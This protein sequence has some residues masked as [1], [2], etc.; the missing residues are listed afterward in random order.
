MAPLR[1]ESRAPQRPWHHH[2]A[3]SSTQLPIHTAVR[4]RTS[5]KTMPPEQNYYCNVPPVLPEQ[6]YCTA[7]QHCIPLSQEQSA[8]CISYSPDTRERERERSIHLTTVCMLL[9]IIV[10]HT[11]HSVHSVGVR[12]SYHTIPTASVY[13]CFNNRD[14]LRPSLHHHESSIQLLLED[15]C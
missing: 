15:L 4:S 9:L 11:I 10:C 12:H 7:H 1:F 3:Q 8:C 13:L 2:Q 6:Y 14:P 5:Q